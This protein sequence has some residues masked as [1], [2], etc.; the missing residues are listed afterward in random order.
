MKFVKTTM[1]G[2]IALGFAQ[3]AVAQSATTGAPPPL[4]SVS[5]E[6]RS[7]PYGTGPRS[8][9]MDTREPSTRPDMTRS[10]ATTAPPPP[11][12]SVSP[13]QRRDLGSASGGATTAPSDNPQASPANP[14]ATT[15]APPPLPS[16]SPEQRREPGTSDSTWNEQ[17]RQWSSGKR[18]A[19]PG[20]NDVTPQRRPNPY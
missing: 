2:A 6:Q 3:L 17:D 13:E 1:C 11:L 18:N 20:S 15:G 7:E 8:A 5:A 4:P 10:P 12:P 9:P 16:V 19:S 14:A